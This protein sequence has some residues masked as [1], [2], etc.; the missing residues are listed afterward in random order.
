MS[1]TVKLLIA[2]VI[3]AL[4]WAWVLHRAARHEARAEAEFP[5]LGQFLVVEGHRV[6][7]LVMGEG[8]DLV[9]LHGSGG[10]LRDLTLS[11]APELAKSYRVIL[12]DRPGHGYTDRV[13]ST[14][15]T[16]KEQAYLLAAAARQLGA[17]KPIVMGHS[18]GGA[19]A[20][21]WAVHEPDSIAALIPLSAPSN[22]W[23][24]GLPLFYRVTSHPLLAPIVTP[25]LAAFV[26]DSRV[27]S[28]VASVFAPNEV[29]EGYLDHFGAP[30]T[31]RRESL[32]ANA[33]QRRNLSDEI[34][35]LVP[36]YRR[37]D[38][39]TEIV[40]GTADTT[41]G[42]SIHSEKLVKQISQSTLTRLE[43]IAHMPQHA[44]PD[45]VIA[46]IHR[47][48]NRAGLRRTE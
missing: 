37:I 5:P 10:N 23:E 28:G 19:V 14:G 43:G 22:R 45:A 8:P 9:L 31:L 20:L 48:A 6:H 21:A 13:S 7:A 30:L 41:V 32:R 1:L 44:A 18:F 25:L 26:P 27:E 12:F 38:I 17:E 36:L 29:P 34:D 46:A 40:H 39:P 42:L 11:L 24:S 15:S 4:F 3:L 35:A 16:L 33:L 47:A 2:L